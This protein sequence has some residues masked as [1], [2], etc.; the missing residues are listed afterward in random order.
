M[1][2]TVLGSGPA[3]PR[4]GGASAGFLLRMDRGTLLV[5]CGH[6]VTG[7]L[8]AATP[9]EDLRAILISHMHPDHFFDLVPLKY[10]LLWE[11][12]PKVPLYLPPGGMAMLDALQRSV[13]GSDT[14]FSEVYD[15]QEYNPEETLGIN[16]LTVR[17]ARTRHPIDCFAMRFSSPSSD[18]R[19]LVYSADTG[20]RES[21]I[22]LM[23]SARLVIVESTLAHY[24]HE[25]EKDIHLTGSL[26]GTLA[27]D[28]AAQRLLLTHYGSS[29]AE[30]ILRDAAQRFGGPTEL[31]IEGQTYSL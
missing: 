23:R 31:A 19:D 25:E 5:D 6:G 17:F 10:A 22:E 24:A 30:V 11:N 14:F 27:A 12:V 20:P 29:D 28:A 1:D 16:G 26:A 9:L 3:A 13:L 7:R 21:M 15:V 2:V 4:P 8:R 18:G